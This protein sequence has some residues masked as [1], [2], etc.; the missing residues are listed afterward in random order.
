MTYLF[1]F[2]FIFIYSLFIFTIV[3]IEAPYFIEVK[4]NDAIG[5]NYPH[6]MGIYAMQPTRVNLAPAWSRKTANVTSYLHRSSFHG[7]WAV[8][9]SLDALNDHKLI[10]ANKILKLFEDG[11]EWWYKN[12]TANETWSKNSVLSVKPI[13]R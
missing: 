2:L 3:I 4:S 6:L 9:V 7:S 11:L 5:L 13:G 8:S 1:I 10:T 12:E